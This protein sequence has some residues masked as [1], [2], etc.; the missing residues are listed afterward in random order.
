MS[1]LE[2]SKESEWGIKFS[3]EEIPRI[4]VG[5]FCQIFREETIFIFHKLFQ[6]TEEKA[7]LPNSL[8]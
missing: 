6:K 7:A 8:Y 1:R 5:E 3:Y 2:T 4:G